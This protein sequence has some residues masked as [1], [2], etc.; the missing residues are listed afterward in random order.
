[1]ILVLPAAIFLHSRSLVSYL[2]CQGRSMERRIASFLLSSCFHI[3]FVIDARDTNDIG[4]SWCFAM[5][6]IFFSKS[7][8]QVG[9]KE[10]ARST[11][12]VISTLMVA[13]GS[14]LPG[15]GSC[16]AAPVSEGWLPRLPGPWQGA[17]LDCRSRFALWCVGS[18]RSRAGLWQRREL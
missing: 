14:Y 7:C 9:D 17:V 3:L 6:W 16:L 13:F 1:M 11:A 8:G 5:F 12:K 10:C 4:K 15:F 2:T 18:P